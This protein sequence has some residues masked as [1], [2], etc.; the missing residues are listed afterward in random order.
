MPS[1]ACHPGRRPGIHRVIMSKSHTNPAR[2]DCSLQS[3]ESSTADPSPS[4][5]SSG[6]WPVRGCR[7]L[8]KNQPVDAVAACESFYRFRFM[9]TDAAQKII[10][11][12]N[13]KRFSIAAG[14]DVNIH[15]DHNGYRTCPRYDNPFTLS[16][17]TSRFVVPVRNPSNC[18][19][20]C[21]MDPGPA[22]GMT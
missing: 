22:A 13:I 7:I 15:Y 5:I 6:E 4:I 2:Y 1:L 9:F 18:F 21:T 17:R 3:T 8:R 20:A 14:E 10:G 11:H 12:A 19:Y 16:F